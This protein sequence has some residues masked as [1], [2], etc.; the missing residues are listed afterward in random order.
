MCQ[1]ASLRTLTLGTVRCTEPGPQ[2]W[3]TDASG[4]SKHLEKNY[5][6]VPTG[7]ESNRCLTEINDKPRFYFNCLK[8]SNVHHSLILHFQN[9][10]EADMGKTVRTLVDSA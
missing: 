4:S 6:R 10:T 3:A 7:Q 5:S 2:R 8:R 1:F 9:V